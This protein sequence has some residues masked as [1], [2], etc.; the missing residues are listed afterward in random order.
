MNQTQ[1][2]INVAVIGTGRMGN[3][4]ARTAANVASSNLLAVVDTDTARASAMAQQYGCASC[5]DVTELLEKFP[6]VQACVVSVP[7]IFHLDVAKQ[8]LPKGI[9][10]LVEKP[11]AATPPEAQELT[12]LAKVNN[13]VL[14]IGHTERFNPGLRAVTAMNLKPKFMDVTRVS[15]MPFRSLDI[16]VV[17]DLMIHDLDIVLHLANSK[18]KSVHA[19]GTSVISPTEDMC[20]AR[21]IFES[22]CVVNITASRMALT[23]QRTMKIF[24]DDAFVN[25]DYA[26][27]SGIVIRKSD[28]ATDIESI[29]K[30]I[31]AGEDLTSLK[32]ADRVTAEPLAFD[33]PQGHDD[34]L[35]AQLDCFLESV[36]DG[37]PV[38]VSGADGSAAVE[39]A[40][41]IVQS[42]KENQC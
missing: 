18:L 38:V 11:I 28:H 20:N 14:Q 8:L 30:R 12:D 32:Y 13:A 25:L 5:K 9:A 37:K 35:T 3:H 6:Q 40:H 29:S 31:L 41:W 42:I 7:T 26:T 17:M 27:R 2:P 33:L 36:R 1:S 15:P 39:A 4:H 10:C 24:A 21:L 34:Q 23:A 22:G 19:V 16:G